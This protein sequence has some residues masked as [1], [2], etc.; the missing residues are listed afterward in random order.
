MFREVYN[1]EPIHSEGLGAVVQSVLK[2]LFTK[3][4]ITSEKILINQMINVLI[5]KYIVIRNLI[6]E[7]L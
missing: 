4:K 6:I 7:S 2:A 3:K 1:K 5:E